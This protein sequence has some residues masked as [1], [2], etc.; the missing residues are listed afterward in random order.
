MGRSMSNL[1]PRTLLG[2]GAVLFVL[3]LAVLVLVV[4]PSATLRMSFCPDYAPGSP[5]L[6]CRVVWYW[7]LASEI[8]LGSGLLASL[9]AAVAA[10][11]KRD[12]QRRDRPAS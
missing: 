5:D 10:L 1:N 8:L 12:R 7:A 3:G 4:W 11:A 6:R 9:G 2:V